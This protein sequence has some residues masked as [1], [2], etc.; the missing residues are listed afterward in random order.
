MDKMYKLTKG[1][2]ARVVLQALYNIKELPDIDKIIWK[3]RARQLKVLKLKNLNFQYDR[4]IRIIKARVEKREEN[5]K[6][7]K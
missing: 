4:A 6:N 7:G 2:K 3:K 5:I 1:D